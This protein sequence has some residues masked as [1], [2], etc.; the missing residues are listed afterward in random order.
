MTGTQNLYKLTQTL[1][2]GSK[3]QLYLMNLK[4][5]QIIQVPVKGDRLWLN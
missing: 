3:T 1:Q 2:Y 4:P 5:S